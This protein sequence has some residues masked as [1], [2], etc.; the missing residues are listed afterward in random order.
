MRAFGILKAERTYMGGLLSILIGILLMV[1]GIFMTFLFPGT[2]EQQGDNFQIIGIA[3][4][5]VSFF[6][7]IGLIVF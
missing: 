1:F 2:K 5:I 7:G 3:I 4:G 6:I